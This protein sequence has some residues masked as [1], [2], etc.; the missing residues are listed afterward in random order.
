M[1]GPWPVASRDSD[2]DP[3]L[4]GMPAASVQMFRRFLDMSRASGPVIF[5][6]QNGPVVL[7]GTR[8]IFAS[9]RA[10]GRGIAGHLN[11][12]RTVR[13][14]RIV[15]A[16]AFTKTSMFHRYVLSSLSELDG[17]FQRWLDEAHA[18]GNGAHL[19]RPPE[20]ASRPDRD[21]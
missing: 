19:I 21:L 5:E 16:E 20:S 4:A 1:P 10:L 18:V 2:F 12:M 6:L 14:P 8:R 3:Y 11:L 13:D 15:K 7:R 9:V 17:E